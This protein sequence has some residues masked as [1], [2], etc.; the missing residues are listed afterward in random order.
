MKKIEQ[1]ADE[2]GITIADRTTSMPPKDL[3]FRK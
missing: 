2:S 1:V 3:L